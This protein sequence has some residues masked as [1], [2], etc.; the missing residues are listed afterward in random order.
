MT[1]PSHELPAVQYAGFWRRLAAYAI[2][3]ILL[4]IVAQILSE[5][6]GIDLEGGQEFALVVADYLTDAVN[7][8]AF[9]PLLAFYA[10]VIILNWLYFA[11][12]E[13]SDKQATL[14]KMILGLIVTDETGKKISFARATGRFWGKA[15]SSLILMIGYLMAIWTKRRQALH[16]IMAK[17]L[18][19]REINK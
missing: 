4:G 11:L 15:I 18:V 8:S 9:F 13:S 14:G 5:I 17:T 2:D 1:D 3:T 12:L 7:F 10:V 16:D 6:V 19:L